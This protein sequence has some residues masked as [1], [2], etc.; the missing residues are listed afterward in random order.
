MTI[1]VQLDPAHFPNPQAHDPVF[2]ANVVDSRWV[3]TQAQLAVKKLA[4]GWAADTPNHLVSSYA[5]LLV[6]G[7]IEG[8]LP[9]GWTPD[10]PPT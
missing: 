7:D 1:F 4:I 8:D 6:W 10:G 3:K 5:D 2:V 9:P